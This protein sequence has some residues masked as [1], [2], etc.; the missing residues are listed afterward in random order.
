MQSSLCRP[1]KVTQLPG[2]RPDGVIL[3]GQS[4]GGWGVVAYDSQPHP[5]VAALISMAGGRGGHEDNQP[6]QNCRPD[7]LAAAAGV[8]GAHAS[9]PMLWIYTANDS[10]FAPPIAAALPDSFVEAGGQA[11]LHQLDPFGSDGHA[12]FFSQGGSAIWGPLV[13][14]HLARM[15]AAP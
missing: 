6:N 12:L 1:A 5:K 13:A 7:A 2:G 8:F 15:H 4:A 14:A 10:F 11:E 9:T 3:I